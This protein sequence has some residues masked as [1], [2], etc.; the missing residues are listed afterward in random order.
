M[1]AAS[2][3]RDVRN[4]GVSGTEKRPRQTC[5]EN[6]VG[7]GEAQGAVQRTTGDERSS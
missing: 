7:D 4:N 1:I 2:V 6:A 3:Y 5:T